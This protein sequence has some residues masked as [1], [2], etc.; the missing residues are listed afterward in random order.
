MFIYF[1]DGQM[2]EVEVMQGSN[3]PRWGEGVRMFNMDF[4]IKHSVWNYHTTEEGITFPIYEI[5]LAAG[6]PDAP[7]REQAP[8]RDAMPTTDVEWPR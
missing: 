1:P 7:E 8:H 6:D 3:L 4:M 2:G 5:Y